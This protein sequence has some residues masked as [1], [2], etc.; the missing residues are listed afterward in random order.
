MSDSSTGNVYN[1]KLSFK[2]SSQSGNNCMK[3][4]SS[5]LAAA[6]SKA[7]NVGCILSSL[8]ITIRNC[9]TKQKTKQIFCLTG[10]I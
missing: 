9:L 10:K 1:Y 5:I 8:K 3:Y 2:A 4:P 6:K 7:F